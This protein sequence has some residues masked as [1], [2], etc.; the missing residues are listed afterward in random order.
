MGRFIRLFPLL[1]VLTLPAQAQF[2]DRLANPTIHV[3]VEHPP[4]LGIKT[5]KIAFGPASGECSDQIIDALIGDFVSNGLE[6]LDRAN[7]QAVLD[8]QNLHLTGYID[9]ASATAIGQILG[10]SALV[11]VKVQRCATQVDR[12]YDTETRYDSKTET[13]YKVRIYMARTRAFLKASIQTVDLATGRIFAAKA[14]DYS[15]ERINKSEEGYPEAP[16]EFDLI[17]TAIQAAV[18]DVHRMFLPWSEIREL[19]YFDDKDCG[20]KQAAQLMKGGDF[21]G[22]L[23]MSA[24]NLQACKAAPKV[25]DK[26]LAHAYYNVGMSHMVLQQYDEALEHFREAM[27]YRP[28]DIVSQSIAECQNAKALSEALQRVETKAALD[29]DVAKSESD[30]AAAERAAS[31]LTNQGVMEMAQ[32]GLS[33]AII[34]QKIKNSVCKFDT[35]SQALASLTKVG[36]SEAVMLEMMNVR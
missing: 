35:S 1:L 13:N 23:E 10:P 26:L 19:V 32:S 22:A 15:P 11:F 2:F 9:Q 4:G 20:L 3:R 17:D 31:T 12:L 24:G 5:E 30:A 7:L 34:I 28:G 25:K 36:V 29:A 21:R 14:L 27:K 33:D 16:S 6:V 8:E 18:I